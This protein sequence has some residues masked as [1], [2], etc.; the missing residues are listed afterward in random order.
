MGDDTQR[1]RARQVE[2]VDLGRFRGERLTSVGSR[3]VSGEQGMENS[4]SEEA[5]DR[6]VA[7]FIPWF[8][9]TGSYPKSAQKHSCV[10]KI[11]CS[12]EVPNSPSQTW[13]YKKALQCIPRHSS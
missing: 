5:I 13:C 1:S 2:V 7:L 11:N 12:S 4:G 3:I 6:R 8:T 9:A 10:Q